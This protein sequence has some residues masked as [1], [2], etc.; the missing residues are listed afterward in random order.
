MAVRAARKVRDANDL[1]SAGD[2]CRFIDQ[3][4][5]DI[6]P[7]DDADESASMHNRE[8]FDP[9]VGHKIGEFRDRRVL[10]CRDDGSA[11]QVTGTAMIR[12]QVFQEI[13]RKIVTFGK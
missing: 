5:D 7:T 6:R 8:T 13:G 3:R 11:H 12:L 9:M 1:R 4:A 10:R 2:V